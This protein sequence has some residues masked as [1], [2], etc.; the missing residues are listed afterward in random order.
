M[1]QKWNQ[2][3]IAAVMGA[4][5]L[6]MTWA[7]GAAVAQQKEGEKTQVKQ[8]MR[9]EMIE[10][11]NAN[12]KNQV[13]TRLARSASLAG[14][15][16]QVSVEDRTVS[17]SGAV[18]SEQE[19]ERALRI[20]RRVRNVRQVKDELSIDQAAVD[21]RRNVKVGDEE[22]AKQVAQK[23][24]NE[25]FPNAEAE[26][27]WFFGWEVDGYAWE[28]DVDVDDGVVMLEGDVDSYDDIADVIQL[29]RAVPGVRS[30]DSAELSA[31]YYD[32]PY[33]GHP[34]N[35]YPYYSRPYYNGPAYRYP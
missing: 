21:K 33:Y 31:D 18:G 27:E 4:F 14:T 6:S 19:K 17:L 32:Y 28:F 25:L 2:T 10:Q 3:Q 26:E 22:L 29:V 23:L 30:V 8:L 35:R 16:I 1:R 5:V 20:A 34:Y 12:I 7:G 13:A 24:V 9:Q 11:Q 15:N